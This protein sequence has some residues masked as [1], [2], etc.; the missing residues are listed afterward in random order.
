VKFVH[1]TAPNG[2]KVGV[3]PDQVVSDHEAQPGVDAPGAQCVLTETSG[4]QAV[5][6]T[7][8]EAEKDL[9]GS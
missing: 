3:N 8:A 9:E 7:C 5:K 4:F 2:K 1:L 6:E